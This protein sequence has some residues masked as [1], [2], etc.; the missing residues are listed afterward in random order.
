MTAVTL[1]KQTKDILRNFSTINSSIV[2][3]EGNVLK[4]ISNAENVLA[5]AVVEEYFPRDFA[6]YD[7]NQF[8]SGLDLFT[9]PVL[10]FDNDNYV[11]IR[12][13][14]RGRRSKYYFSDPQIT[15]KAAPDREIKFPGGNINFKVNNGSIKTLSKAALVYGL[16]DFT[17]S[18]GTDSV[19]LSVRDKEDD[20]S[21]TFDQVVS[22]NSDD[23]YTLDF[24]VENLRLFGVNS[25]DA[26][27]ETYN[28]SVS[29]RMISKWEYS[30]FDITYYIALEP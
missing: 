11:T 4:T 21:N 2:V 25:A 28:V 1:S 26:V 19:T 17:V 6:I 22:G 18:S 16:P 8:L 15:M 9:D 29:S 20:T 27:D 10:H 12:D 30:A 14:G 24:K 7:L 5:Q 23:E 13:S 3:K